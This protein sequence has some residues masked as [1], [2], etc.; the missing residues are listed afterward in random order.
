M[1][2]KLSTANMGLIGRAAARSASLFGVDESKSFRELALGQISRNPNQPRT[3][4]DPDTLQGL[5]ASI[6]QH[7]VIQPILVRETSPDVYQIIAGERRFR[8]CELV[9]RATIPAIVTTTE[10][11]AVLALLENVQ[12]EDLDP[13]DLAG[14]LE[15]LLQQHGATHD[16]LATLIGKSRPYVTRVLGLQRLPKAVRDEFHD[17]RTVSL[18][19]LLEIAEAD[20]EEHQ[21]ALW[22]QA[23]GGMTVKALRRSKQDRAATPAAVSPTE[24][25]LRGSRRLSQHLER[26]KQEGVRLGE[27]QQAALRTLRD[28]IDSML[29]E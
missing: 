29:E 2:R 28:H 17:H 19:V 24:K 13:F 16:Q 20:G 25:L 12:R 6:E 10:D 5:A 23:K 14:F 22:S 8:A 11:P 26:L 1:S 27:V 7:G 18:S 15:R 4:F 3:W 9:A 21:L